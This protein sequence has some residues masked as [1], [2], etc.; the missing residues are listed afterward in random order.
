[1]KKLM[2]NIIGR[3]R[4]TFHRKKLRSQYYSYFGF[5]QW[6]NAELT[7]ESLFLERILPQFIKELKSPVFFDVGANEGE[8]SARL[9]SVFPNCRVECFEP[10]ALPASRL[11]IRFQDAKNLTVNECAV[12]GECGSSFLY[13]YAYGNTS[14]HASLF[15]DV[16]L[17]HHGAKKL[18]KTEVLVKTIDQHCLDA[19]IFQI[20]LLKI[21]TEGS[22]FLALSGARGKI[23]E[24]LI[25]FIQFEFNAMNVFSRTFLYDFYNILSNYEIYRMHRAGLIPLGAYS[26]REEVFVFHNLLAVRRPLAHKIP[27]RYILRDRGR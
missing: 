14:E 11:R 23:N 10:G 17:K 20:S 6:Q 15:A 8:Y 13:D 22:E 21:D 24:G 19:K 7:G 25:D 16:L 1:M 27:E 2:Y 3:L 9:L 12:G 26:P 4:G 18:N 5:L